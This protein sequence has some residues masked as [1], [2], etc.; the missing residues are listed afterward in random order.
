MHES[1]AF[2]I[3]KRRYFCRKVAGLFPKSGST[4]A[5]QGRGKP[6][7]FPYKIISD[8]SFLEMK[9][10]FCRMIP[11]LFDSSALQ[12]FRAWTKRY[13]RFVIVT[14]VS[15]D[16]DAMGSALAMLHYLQAKGCEAHVIVP[17]S[18][19]DFFRWMPQVGSVVQYDFRS[20]LGDSLLAEAEAVYCLDFNTLSRAGV[21][22]E[23]LRTLGKPLMLIDHHPSPGNNFAATFSCPALCATAE[24]LFRL[25]DEAGDADLIGKECATCLYTGLMTDTGAF[26]YNSARPEIFAIVSRLLACGIDKDYI[27][28]RIFCAQSVGRMKLMGYALY[29]K[30]KIYP[31]LHSALIWLTQDEL[32][33]FSYVKG[34]TEG[35]VNLPLQMKGIQF[36]CFLRE[37]KTMIKVSLRSVGRFSCTDFAVSVFNGGGHR[38]ASGGEFYG[39]MTAAV[40]RFEAGLEQFRP[41]LEAQPR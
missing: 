16:G 34:D 6:E 26:T 4:F 36:A 14:H 24:V 31:D 8:A 33:R 15:P 40:A 3:E 19:P 21:V 23:K 27:Y 22:G 1:A 30:M 10:Y 12:E 39:D 17:N 41:Q 25:I 32:K 18:F 29:A 37:D 35:F 5:E 11:T 7:F 9:L 20:E 13:R 2:F 38:N 28:R